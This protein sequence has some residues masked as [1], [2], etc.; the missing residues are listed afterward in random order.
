M[1]GAG[2][3]LHPLEVALLR[4]LVHAPRTLSRNRNPELFSQPSTRRIKRRAAHLRS[5]RAELTGALREP[6]AVTVREDG[7]RVLT[8]V[9]ED[10]MRRTATISAIEWEVLLEDPD[11][12]ARLSG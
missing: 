7:A 12:R 9:R 6:P 8:T 10:G 5:L 11:V 1:S 3:E 4:R 2:D